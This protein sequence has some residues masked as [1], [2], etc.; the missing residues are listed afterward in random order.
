MPTDIRL[1]HVNEFI[2]AT[3]HGSFDLDAS[4]GV[5]AEIAKEI[6]PDG[7]NVL[8]DVRRRRRTSP[9]PKS[10]ASSRSSPVSR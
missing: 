1:V 5:L 10:R 9:S 2:R 3:V 6:P 8:I 4:I 7:I